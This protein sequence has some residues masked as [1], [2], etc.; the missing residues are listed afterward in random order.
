VAAAVD[1]GAAAARMT[2]A[3]FGG[4]ALAL[5]SDDRRE[6]VADAVRA[7]FA[8]REFRPPATFEVATANGAH[9]LT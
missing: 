4:S 5:V 9:R 2:G 7:A 6:P 8:L 1:S 3:G